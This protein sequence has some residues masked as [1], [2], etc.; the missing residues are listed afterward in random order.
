MEHEESASVSKEEV[1]T[2]ITQDEAASIPAPESPAVARGND[3]TVESLPE[4][5]I[6]QKPQIKEMIVEEK[7][8]IKP[9]PTSEKPTEIPKEEK[10]K[11]QQAPVASSGWGWGSLWTQATSVVDSLSQTTAKMVQDLVEEHPVREIVDKEE[12]KE[13]KQ[14]KDEPESIL[15]PQED[16]LDKGMSFLGGGVDMLSSYINVGMN[17]V[18]E[19]VQSDAVKEY[20]NAAM[21]FASNSIEKA[22]QVTTNATE[23]GMQ[24]G[25]KFAHQGVDA[26]E[27]VG[28]SA[29]TFLTV[30]EA[31]GDKQ[32]I[33][34]IFLPSQ[35]ASMTQEEQANFEETLNR[36][37]FEENNGK[38]HLQVLET[39]STEYAAKS[40]NE[41]PKLEDDQRKKYN[42]MAAKLKELA[43]FDEDEDLNEDH[44]PELP[45]IDLNE[46]AS[47][48]LEIVQSLVKTC[49]D[50]SVEM[51]STFRS[52]LKD[53]V[54]EGSEDLLTVTDLTHLT[55]S[56]LDKVLLE[57]V[58]RISQ[59]S[60]SGVEQLLRVVESYLIEA[61]Q[62]PAAPEKMYQ[63]SIYL[64]SLS[65]ILVADLSAVSINFI[66]S[67]RIISDDGKVHINNLGKNRSE[68][69]EECAKCAEDIE[70]KTELHVNNIYME[71]SS[72]VS[73]I[74]ESRKFLLQ[75]CKFLLLSSFN[76][77]NAN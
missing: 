71:T 38:A 33:R 64:F 11:P 32:R 6:D 62:K 67:L 26:L 57:S 24:Y 28:K 13:G 4:P 47:K 77:Q 55:A 3:K 14:E 41:E 72:G 48:Q 65:Q 25:E 51:L 40:L 7:E 27:A 70:T 37:Y 75:I 76:S 44:Q 20:Q 45:Q 9:A 50:Q 35:Q 74:Q 10:Q 1:E 19:T 16:L 30:Q 36:N 18:A 66:D 31:I 52:E 12:G 21:S 39:L 2:T 56:Y 69:A 58:Q 43:D 5:K 59:F 68:E 29:L 49:K 63:K 17:K 34:P 22:K 15:P 23:M 53:L 73:N 60:A 61:D 8:E 42:E 46:P 54:P